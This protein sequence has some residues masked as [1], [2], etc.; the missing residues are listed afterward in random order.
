MDTFLIL[1][2]GVLMLLVVINLVRGI[3]AFMKR[4]KEDLNR[5]P[6]A[7]GPTPSQLA[8]NKMMS[9]RIKFQLLAVLVILLL[10][11]LSK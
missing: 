11:A 1:I 6:S 10:M 3:T 7:T 2:I 5:D 4:S 9:N 8:Q